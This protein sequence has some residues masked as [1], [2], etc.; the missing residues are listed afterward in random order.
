MIRTRQLLF[1]FVPALLV[2]G[3]AFFVRVIQYEPLY[4]KEPAAATSDTTFQIPIYPQD[5]IWGDKKAAKTVI[6]FADFSCEAC[7]DED[8]LLEKLLAEYPK[9]IKVIW[10]GIPTARFPFDTQ[11]AH[12]YAYCAQEQGKFIPFKQFAFANQDSLSNEIL[13]EISKQIPLDEKKLTAC[14]ESGEAA[15]FIEQNNTLATVLNIQAV[16][17]AFIDNQQVNIPSTLDGWKTLLGL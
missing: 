7:K 15:A 6:L 3:F 12:E 13:A 16:P 14:L 9:K 17:I 11:L 1:V 4:P 8:V 10:K 5:P 2:V